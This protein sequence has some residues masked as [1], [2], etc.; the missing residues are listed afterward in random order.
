MSSISLDKNQLKTN[1][2]SGQDEPQTNLLSNSRN[3]K[4]SGS[5]D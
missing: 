3:P 4:R 2:W 5:E 1:S